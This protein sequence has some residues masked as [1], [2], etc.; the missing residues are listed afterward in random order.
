VTDTIWLW[1]YV[2]CMAA[3]AGFI[4]FWSRKPKGVPH[5]EYAAAAFIPIWSGLAYTASA[6]G[7]G[8]VEVGDHDVYL[9]RYA[10]WIVTTPLLLAGL[11]WT[12]MYS[13]PKNAS[14][15]VALMG[16]NVIM[17][18]SG[19]MAD[20]SGESE[21]KWLWY[22]IGCV[23]LAVIFHVAWGPLRKISMSQGEQVGTTYVKVAALLSVLWLGYPLFWA[24]GPS[25][26]GVF[27]RST[28]VALFVLLPIVSKVGFSLY[29]L[30]SLRK[31]GERRPADPVD[32][33]PST[34]SERST[35]APQHSQAGH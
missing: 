34:I 24:L 35:S 33:S 9:T 21:I 27:D 7:Q 17:I 10:D 18:L 22:G 28:D 13:V 11:A 20:V 15:I 30:S 32:H 29:D 26:V 16:A 19:L 1:F 12:A 31:L 23:C 8:V 2:A 6:L 3:G 4:G 25:G 5:Y 14:L